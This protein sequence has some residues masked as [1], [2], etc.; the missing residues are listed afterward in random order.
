[1]EVELHPFSTRELD[2]DKKSFSH[3]GHFISPG[4]DTISYQIGG[5]AG[6]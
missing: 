5:W 2:G 1:M 6:P 3:S 4:K